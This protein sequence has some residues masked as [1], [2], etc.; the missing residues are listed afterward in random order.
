MLNEIKINKIKFP[1]IKTGN[2]YI[3]FLTL[4]SIW[5]ISMITSLP[6]LAVTPILGDLD[7]IFPHISDL[8]IQMLSS[9]PNLLIIPFVLLSGKISDSKGKQPMRSDERSVGNESLSVCDFLGMCAP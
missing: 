5:S 4:I 9:L 1:A 2:G 8:E 3:P 7:K 6:G